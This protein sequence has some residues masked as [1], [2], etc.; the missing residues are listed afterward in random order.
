MFIRSAHRRHSSHHA[1]L[2]QHFAS[3]D[4]CGWPNRTVE[5]QA[6]LR[7]RS[8]SRRRQPKIQSAAASEGAARELAHRAPRRQ[9][10][11]QACE[12]ME[13][14]RAR[15]SSVDISLTIIRVNLQSAQSPTPLLPA[16]RS[17]DIEPSKCGHRSWK[18]PMVSAA[19]GRRWSAGL[20]EPSRSGPDVRVG[21]QARSAGA[22]HRAGSRGGRRR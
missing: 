2:Q 5:R 13:S 15:S 8:A 1:S 21:L 14:L 6:R 11:L 19:S 3:R 4:S 20:P 12:T 16:S 17:E 7:G 9:L 18:Q 22:A 10:V